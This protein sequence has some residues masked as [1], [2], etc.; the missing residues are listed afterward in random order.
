MKSQ[1][2]AIGCCTPDVAGTTWHFVGAM[3]DGEE[4]DA[5]TSNWRSGSELWW[6]S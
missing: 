2:G 6:N 5:E 1:C 4:L 3:L